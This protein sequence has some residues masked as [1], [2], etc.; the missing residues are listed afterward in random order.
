MY[1]G[2]LF[3]VSHASELSYMNLVVLNLKGGSTLIAPVVD[4]LTVAELALLN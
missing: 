1:K 4:V 3:Y 2:Y